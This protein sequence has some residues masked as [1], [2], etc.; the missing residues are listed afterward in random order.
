MRACTMLV[1]VT[2]TCH[3]TY[4]YLLCVYDIHNHTSLYH[5][6]NTIRSVPP[7]VLIRTLS[8]CARPDL[9]CVCNK[10]LSWNSHANLDSTYTKGAQ[11]AAACAVLAW[12]SPCRS[13]DRSAGGV[14]YAVGDGRKRR[15]AV[16]SLRWSGHGVETGAVEGSKK[17]GTALTQA[18]TLKAAGLRKPVFH[19]EQ[20][21]DRA[22]RSPADQ[23]PA[24]HASAN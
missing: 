16:R 2:T 13:H 1:R 14:A 22:R 8:I 24:W 23:S 20:S 10:Q 11:A 5:T 3:S 17:V 19:F 12:C 21:S 6:V 18:V 4:T 15:T 7:H 9:T